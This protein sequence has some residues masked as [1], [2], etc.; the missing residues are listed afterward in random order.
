MSIGSILLVSGEDL[1]S[2][3]PRAHGAMRSRGAAFFHSNRCL[4]WGVARRIPVSVSDSLSPPTKIH[5][6]GDTGFG[7]LPAQLLVQRAGER[8][9]GLVQEHLPVEDAM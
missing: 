2:G 9:L 5:R 1:L 4:A 8:I 7:T 3:P 6:R